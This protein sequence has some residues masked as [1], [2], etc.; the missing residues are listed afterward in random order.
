MNM[1]MYVIY[2]KIIKAN[3]SSKTK[4]QSNLKFSSNL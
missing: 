3:A 1:C 2:N 4:T